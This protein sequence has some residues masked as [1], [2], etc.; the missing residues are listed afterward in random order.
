M[1]NYCKVSAIFFKIIILAIIIWLAGFLYFFKQISVD[2]PLILN[3]SEAIIVLTGAKGR[4]DHGVKLLGA[5]LAPYLF[6]SGVAKQASVADLTNHLTESNKAIISRMQNNI[7]L[8]KD[9]DSTEDNII[10]ITTWLKQQKF[11]SFILV[12]SNYHLPRTLKLIKKS[13]NN[14]EV[15]LSPVINK[16]NLANLKIFIK[17]YNKYLFTL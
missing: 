4:I 6:I 12:T 7:T 16:I 13:G 10:E 15:Q 8:G 3:K 1:S 17:E 14:F 11:N 2:S 5:G 9:A